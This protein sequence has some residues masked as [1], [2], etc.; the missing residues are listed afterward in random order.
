ME[1]SCVNLS[2]NKPPLNYSSQPKSG[3]VINS[4]KTSKLNSYIGGISHSKSSGDVNSISGNVSSSAASSATIVNATSSAAIAAATTAAAA[5][6]LSAA[7]HLLAVNNQA[8][9]NNRIFK[10]PK[11]TSSFTIKTSQYL[12]DQN[13]QISKKSE[14]QQIF[15]KLFKKKPWE[16]DRVNIRPGFCLFSNN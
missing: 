8:R 13:S 16:I 11:S 12:D 5:A 1:E 4:S 9:P 10:I 7:N 14:L 6:S 2:H 3:L 15:S